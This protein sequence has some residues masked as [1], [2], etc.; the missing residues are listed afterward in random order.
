[1]R[2]LFLM[3]PVMAVVLVGCAA[4]TDYRYSCANELD[5]AWKELDIAK[6]EGFAG[7]V[8]YSKALTLITSAKTQ[9]QFEAYQGCTEKSKK[10]RFYI[11]ESRAGR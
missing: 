11:R 6:A 2:K 7:T 9:Q 4:K 10:A 3:L 1:M 5:A 8:S